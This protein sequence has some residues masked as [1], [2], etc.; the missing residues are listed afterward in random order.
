MLYLYAGQYFIIKYYMYL[1]LEVMTSSS[2][3]AEESQESE[4]PVRLTF[5]LPMASTTAS[6]TGLTGVGGGPPPVKAN[7]TV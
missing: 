4:I 2:C 7:R 5:S 6:V 1:S 3:K